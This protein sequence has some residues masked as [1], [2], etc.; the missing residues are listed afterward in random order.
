[1]SKREARS[2]LALAVDA[3]TLGV[4]V[5]LAGMLLRPRADVSAAATAAERVL[6]DSVWQAAWQGAHHNGPIDAPVKVLQFSDLECPA[7]RRF[8]AEMRGL[9]DASG[10]TVAMGFVHHPLAQHRFARRAAAVAECAAGQG[11]FWQAYDSLLARQSEFGLVPW[12]SILS[13]GMSESQIDRCIE[14]GAYTALLTAHS[15]LGEA[16]V[17][18][19]TPTVVVNGTVLPTP[20]SRAQLDSIIARARGSAR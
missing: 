7:C 1:M 19:G 2:T 18:A 11:M 17:V 6:E 8:A 15:A 13:N 20:P 14:S 5:L 12:A 4:L 3:A 16:V 9:V 10:G